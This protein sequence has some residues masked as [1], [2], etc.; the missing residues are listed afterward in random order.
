MQQFSHAPPISATGNPTL[1]WIIVAIGA[2]I[3]IYWLRALRLARE[4][5]RLFLRNLAKSALVF[6]VAAIALA[7]GVHLPE[8]QVQGLSACI[9]FI[10]FIRWQSR[11]RSRYVPSATRRAITARDL[12]GEPLD[13]QK[14]HIDHVWPHSRGGSNTADNLR[15]IDKT[16]NLRKG[17]KRPGMR[18]MF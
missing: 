13:S 6:L 16:K 4:G 1:D 14:H 8:G 2:V 12:K 11:K 10:A 3:A 7:E 17:A 15:V 18:E 5:A 9:A